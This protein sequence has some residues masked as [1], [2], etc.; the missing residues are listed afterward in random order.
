MFRQ[1]KHLIVH[2]RAKYVEQ[3]DMAVRDHLDSTRE[4]TFFF[5]NNQR[6]D[7]E[8]CTSDIHVGA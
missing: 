7:F 3:L 2:N 6:G 8:E 4:E 5:D 1:K